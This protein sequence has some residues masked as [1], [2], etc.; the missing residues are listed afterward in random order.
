MA[1]EKHQH[2]CDDKADNGFR[3]KAM[4]AEK[5]QTANSLTS[6]SGIRHIAF[7]YGSYI[8][9][10]IYSGNYNNDKSRCRIDLNRVRCVI[11]NRVFLPNISYDVG[12]DAFIIDTSQ[13]IDSH[14]FNDDEIDSFIR[15]IETCRDIIGFV[16]QIARDYFR[17]Y[18]DETVAS[19][20][21]NK[22]EAQFAE[23]LSSGQLYRLARL[24]DL[25]AFRE[26]KTKQT[27]E[28]IS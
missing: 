14:M 13:A 28:D 16:R 19:D 23:L 6:N 22:A 20:V 12:K 4:R 5:I 9:D 15:Q 27:K 26:A 24:P 17:N 7:R 10:F 3:D 18:A 8:I 11:T 2:T 1:R 25:P 21:Q